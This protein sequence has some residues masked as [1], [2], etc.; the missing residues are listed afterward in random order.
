[1]QV[2]CLLLYLS[3]ILL[4]RNADVVIGCDRLDIKIRPPNEQM[5][6]EEK[7]EIAF[8]FLH[9]YCDVYPPPTEKTTFNGG[10]E[11]PIDYL[12]SKYH[13]IDRLGWDSLRLVG[14]RITIYCTPGNP[15]FDEDQLYQHLLNLPTIYC[16]LLTVVQSQKQDE[17]D[18]PL[19]LAMYLLNKHSYYNACLILSKN[20]TLDLDK[21]KTLCQ[22]E[23]ISQELDKAMCLYIPVT[24]QVVSSRFEYALIVLSYL[25]YQVRTLSFED[26]EG[27]L[28]TDLNQITWWQDYELNFINCHIIAKLTLPIYDYSLADN[29]NPLLTR[30]QPKCHKLFIT[31]CNTYFTV[32][33][34]EKFLQFN[35]L[36]DLVIGW[37]Q[38]I[39][40]QEDLLTANVQI[41]RL[42]I[43]S[44]PHQP[45]SWSMFNPKTQAK[46][47]VQQLI[48]RWNR[49]TPCGRHWSGITKKEIMDW[50]GI[51]CQ[52]VKFTYV[53]PRLDYT[54]TLVTLTELGLE[55]PNTN[56]W[57]KY[58]CQGNVVSSESQ[59]PNSNK[60]SI[61]APILKMTVPSLTLN[62]A[63]HIKKKD[64]ILTQ[65]RRKTRV[66]QFCQHLRYECIHI[67]GSSDN[68]F[69][70][71]EKVCLDLLETFGNLKAESLFMNDV[72]AAPVPSSNQAAEVEQIATLPKL[73]TTLK[74]IKLTDC[75]ENVMAWVLSRYS[76]RNSAYIVISMNVAPPTL[77]F[78]SVLRGSKIQ[79]DC[80]IQLYLAADVFS[81]PAHLDTIIAHQDILKDDK[82]VVVSTHDPTGQY[83]DLIKTI[84]EY[85]IK[86]H[87]MP[88][89]L[90]KELLNRPQVQEVNLNPYFTLTTVDL[91]VLSQHYEEIVGQD[92]S[93]QIGQ[94]GALNLRLASPITNNAQLITI[95]NWLDRVF[96][97]ATTLCLSYTP[98]NVKDLAAMSNHVSTH[99]PPTQSL[100]KITLQTPET[101]YI[102]WTHEKYLN[103]NPT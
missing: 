69:N 58:Q 48:V 60:P 14:C 11:C 61:V 97:Q 81:R 19:Y 40:Y 94:V 32:I 25:R 21:Q 92:T 52:C 24:L 35:P 73:K 15:G 88:F 41:G 85:G 6:A 75:S 36:R 43:N 79:P 9:H 5:T 49:S 71:Q 3:A 64:V 70:L 67:V 95:I 89:C 84:L 45:Q 13:R 93:Q 4:F 46:I 20:N 17:P 42:T 100:L 30:P 31:T 59:S 38:L 62:L 12:K 22:K 68:P 37:N 47:T 83:P 55:L 80:E 16:N 29:T 74:H 33:N 66:R 44:V 76:F 63:K 34:L 2:T 56:I 77:A 10:P 72:V 27:N 103:A 28:S 7:M 23:H 90:I 96:P 82:V 39:P 1:M 65:Y 101:I 8:Q 51:N 26:C 91:E 57:G 54:M 102:I 50:F 98:L 78:L 53:T 99:M 86:L 18:L 87:V